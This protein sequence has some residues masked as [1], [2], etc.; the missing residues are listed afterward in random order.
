MARQ[1]GNAVL[2][3]FDK[4]LSTERI[5]TQAA[6]ENAIVVH[7]AIGG[8]TNAFL[9][10]P[11]IAHELRLKFSLEMVSDINNRVPFIV[12]VRPSGMH[13]T[14]LLWAAG[15][16]PAIMRELEDYLHLDALTVTGKTLGHNLAD[17]EKNGYFDTI[18]RFLENCAMSKVD[19]IRPVSDPL[20]ESG[21]LAVLWVN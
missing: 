19:L 11:A 18:P 14:S 9:H 3:L 1:T 16:V 10:L 7:A 4:R 20:N 21:G 5:I 6:L 8:S 15:G 2:T 12:N 13:P 17:L